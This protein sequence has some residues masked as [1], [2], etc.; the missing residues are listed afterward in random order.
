[1][2]PPCRC[3]SLAAQVANEP[4]DVSA[5]GTGIG[6]RARGVGA[7][8][9]DAEVTEIHVTAGKTILQGYIKTPPAGL[10][11]LVWN[12]FDADAK[13]VIIE[14]ERNDLAGVEQVII[15]DDGDGMNREAAERAFA[16]VGDSWKL[17]PGT[18]TDDGRPVHGRYGRG[19]YAAFSIGN[20]VN[21]YSTARTVEGAE[22][23]T[24]NLQGNRAALDRFKVVDATLEGT[25]TGTRVVIG[26]VAPEAA[27]AREESTALR[28]RLLTEFALHLDRYSDF[29]IEFLGTEVD[30]QA[31]SLPRLRSP[32][33]CPGASRAKPS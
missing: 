8:C 30:P 9:K 25:E 23:Q 11:E 27:A 18:L 19:R 32:W 17:M 12:A 21:W 20:S 13:T 16:T 5:P 14:V 7:S 10:C 29:A 24:I 33:R 26:T 4:A 31:S 2:V 15:T 28:Q 22:L 3:W 6:E 1:M